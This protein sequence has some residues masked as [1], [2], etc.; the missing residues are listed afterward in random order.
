LYDQK[1]EEKDP[2]YVSVS[3]Y[4][5]EISEHPFG[6]GNC[7]QYYP[8]VSVRVCDYVFCRYE[9][10]HEE[11]NKHPNNR[12]PVDRYCQP[13][14]VCVGKLRN[15]KVHTR[16]DEYVFSKNNTCSGNTTNEGANNRNMSYIIPNTERPELLIS[17]VPKNNVN[18]YRCDYGIK[19]EKRDWNIMI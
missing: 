6:E 10:L 1:G 12:Q 2:E 17:K 7:R 9:D 4:L 5:Y 14:V 3:W 19:A 16:S 15:K 11:E 8:E 18:I 13:H